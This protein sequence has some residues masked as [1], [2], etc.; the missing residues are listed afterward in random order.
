MKKHEGVWFAKGS[1]VA[2]LALKLGNAS[3]K[4]VLKEAVGA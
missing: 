3:K 1:E 4:A 2:D